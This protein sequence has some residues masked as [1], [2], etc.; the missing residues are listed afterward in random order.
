MH[1][2]LLIAPLLGAYIMSAPESEIPLSLKAD[3][4]QRDMEERFL[5]EGQ[6]LCKLKLPT[7]Q[8]EF[9]AYNM[10]DNAYMTGIYV[11]TLAMKYAVSHHPSDLAAAQR[12]L[13][14]LHLLNAV[15]GVPGVLAR[16]AWP[17]AKPLDD[18]GVWRDSACGN[19]VWRGDVSTDQVAGVMFGF[20]LA[21]E[22]IADEAEKTRIARDTTAIVQ[23]VLAHEMRIVDVDEKPTRW[24]RYDSQYV[25]RSEKMN[26][27]LWLQALKVAAVTSGDARY[28]ALYKKW[29]LDEGYAEIAV[30]ARRKALPKIPGVINHS[31]DVLLFLAYVP[32]LMYEQ[33]ETLRN[34]VLASVKRSWEG[35]GRFP[36]VK[37]ERNPFYGF[38]VAKFLADTSGVQEGIRTLRWF[39]FDMKWNQ[40]TIARYE[41]EVGRSL[42][43]PPE[44]PVPD[45]GDAIPIDRRV[46]T[47]SAWVQDP[48]HS[49]G[50]RT[51]DES[52]EYNGHDYLLAY[53]MG[54]FYGF[55]GDKE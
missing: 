27:L 39:P 45:P 40:S 52:L 16:A 41:K 25:S 4:F 15:S 19:Y 20:A 26:A 23:R 14:A 46:K 21:Y 51:Q 8:R 50:D 18:D 48:Y 13:Q 43:Y 31:D 17:K 36:G 1:L 12:S 44:S 35:E 53:W 32:L 3:L 10:P 5:L 28:E 49:A 11:G 38:V 7:P 6:A 2:W 22:L 47:W 34:Y 37:P 29:A 9:I 30:N 54:R 42:I 55:I 24:G 33:E